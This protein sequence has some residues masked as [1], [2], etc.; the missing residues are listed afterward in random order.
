MPYFYFKKLATH[1]VGGV[2]LGGFM[3]L[4]SYIAFEYAGLIIGIIIAAFS[5]ILFFAYNAMFAK[6][7]APLTMWREAVYNTNK[8][9]P[10]IVIIR[11]RMKN[12]RFYQRGDLALSQ[13]GALFFYGNPIL[14][15]RKLLTINALSAKEAERPIIEIV[16]TVIETLAD[17]SL[18]VETQHPIHVKGMNAD[19]HEIN[20]QQ[21]ALEVLQE[22]DNNIVE[23]ATRGNP[24]QIDEKIKN[25]TVNDIKPRGY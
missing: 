2:I 10:K 3:A 7:I 8:L 20:R 11:D 5:L 13:F 25:M 18:Y 12:I 24:K 14:N 16:D 22:Y 17:G 23:A 19:Y 9:E 21:D 1:A 15:E 6:K 4:I